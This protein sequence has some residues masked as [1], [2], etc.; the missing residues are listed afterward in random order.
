M[1]WS[2][3][4]HQIQRY[5][6][7]RFMRTLTYRAEILT[8]I[9]SDF[10]PFFVLFMVWQAI[11]AGPQ[12]P[13]TLSLDAVIIYYLAAFCIQGLTAVHFESWRSRDIRLGQIDHFM[14]KPFSYLQEITLG[15][16]GSKLFYYLLFLPIFAGVAV[17]TVSAFDL[18]LPSLVPSLPAVLT[19]L[20]LLI[21]AYILQLCI[22]ICITLGTFWIEGASGLEHFKTLTL[23]LLSGSLMPLALMP[24][25]LQT[26]TLHS[27]LRFTYYVP[28]VVMTEGYQLT[29]ADWLE[30]ALI[31][32]TA[33]AAVQYIW[34]Q[35]VYHYTSS[36]GG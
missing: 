11:Y 27:P 32:T 14:V 23:T 4:F 26:L 7:L 3:Q 33:I 36:G 22:G 15:D 35:G 17:L 16:I 12:A 9:L 8:W 19:L 1:Q 18:S 29:S 21:C 31:T 2:R 13:D 20:I 30:L 6:A 24:D 34:R 5:L 10:L 25:W 28:I